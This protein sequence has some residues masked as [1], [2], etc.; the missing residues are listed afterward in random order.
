MGSSPT[1]STNLS[2]T[3]ET[4]VPPC[5]IFVTPT[6][7]NPNFSFSKPSGLVAAHAGWICVGSW[8]KKPLW[9]GLDAFYLD[10]FIAKPEQLD[11]YEIAAALYNALKT[12][13]GWTHLEMAEALGVRSRTAEGMA[14]G[15]VSMVNRKKLARLA[16]SIA[17]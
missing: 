12:K 4:T 1:A 6:A 8:K 11:E 7:P 17:G 2:T 15:R 3:Y 9:F 14:L 16:A 10:P 5:D 13:H